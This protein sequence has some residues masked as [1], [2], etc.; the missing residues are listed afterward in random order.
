MHIKRL[1]KD[2]RSKLNM[3][4][5]TQNSDVIWASLT[6]DSRVPLSSSLS[7]SAPFPPSHEEV[8]VKQWITPRRGV[9]N[10]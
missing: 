3:T 4:Y 9:W 7:S 8:K 2:H 6:A 5:H 1:C 10:I